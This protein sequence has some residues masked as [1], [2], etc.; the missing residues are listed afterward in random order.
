[1]DSLDRSGKV[2]HCI[3]DPVCGHDAW[4]R[5][6]MVAEAECVGDELAAGVGH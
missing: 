3:K 1:M 4:D 6:G 2:C 5:D